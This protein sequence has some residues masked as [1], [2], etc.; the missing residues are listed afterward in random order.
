MKT[1]SLIGWVLL[2]AGLLALIIVPFILFQE[3][4]DAAIAGFL[5]AGHQPVAVAAAVVALMAGD[6]FL[7][8][9]SSVVG[10]AAG[11]LLGATAG[12]LAAWAGLT[13]GC[14]LAYGFGALAGRPAVARV[15]GARELS[16]TET[17][18]AR[19]GDW[20][21]VLLRAVPVLAESS[22]IWAGA[23]RMEL[24]RFLLLS[25]LANLGI[26]AVYA[27]IGSLIH[28]TDGFLYAFAA[29]LLLPALAM[30]LTRRVGAVDS[31]LSG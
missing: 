21:I 26:A 10:T 31:P 19:Y 9:P 15:A 7:P 16:R 30:V 2:A 12:T 29:A 11:T 4:I 17:L 22:V 24:R 27:G 18:A 25:G 1:R 28:G 23:G 3:R 20:V 5:D 14:V 13:L 6:V 8:V